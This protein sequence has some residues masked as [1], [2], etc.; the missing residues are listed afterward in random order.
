MKYILFFLM[1]AFACSV[2]GQQTEFVDFLKL[3]AEIKFSTDSSLVKGNYAV[4]FYVKTKVDTIFIDA[5]NITIITNPSISY[6]AVELKNKKLKDI[7]N[8]WDSDIEVG[9]EDDRI[10]VIYDFVENQGYKVKFDYVSNPKKA[11]YFLKRDNDWSI[12]TQGQGKY[13]SNWLPSIDDVNEKME[14]NISITYDIDY[15]VI[16]NGKLIDKQINDSTITWRYDMEKPMP[17][18]LVALAIGKYNKRVETSKSGIPL[19]LYYYP[20]DS[21]KV[22][23]TY[24]YSKRM[25]DFLETE[26]GF[27]YPWQNYKQVPVH[28]FLYA[29][30]ENTSL[31]IFSDAFVVDSTGFNDK[32][33]VNVNAH[34][35]A[36]QWFGDLVTAKSGEHHWL[37]E[38]FATYYA[39]LAEGNI[40]GG[41]YYFFEL[42]KSAQDLARQDLA[43]QGTSL[44]N[45]KSSSLTFYQRGAWVLHALREKV[46]ADIYR[47]AVKN[48]LEK[49]Q[50]S[51]AETNDFINEVAVLFEGNL[52]SFVNKW[53][54]AKEFPFDDAIM[55]LKQQ[56]VFINEYI[57]IDCE[58]K[59]S[60]CTDY[61]K[62]YASD[63]AKIKVIS[64]APQLVTN[65]TFKS[66]LK[67]R[68]AIAQY[69]VDI[70]LD[71]KPN[72][73]SLIKDD[74]YL[75]KE[76][77]LYNLWVNFPEERSK[78]LN[79]LKEVYGFSDYN[80]R[81]LW[82]VLNLN[83]LEYQS[84]KNE[85]LYNELLSYTDK[86][87]NAELRMNA[88]RYLN[89][90]KACNT[91][92]QNNL[93]DAK[94]H[95]N[96]Q[97]VKFSKE[98]LEQLK[99]NQQ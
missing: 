91:E 4:D 92:C 23:S 2:N 65:N 3:E 76:Y 70:P 34:E 75:T 20:E 98:M 11:L 35:L 6:T 69:V 81:L 77:A 48:Y 52:E 78:Y 86:K 29:G 27:E 37:Q 18:Y 7:D 61:L 38:G 60:K 89:L 24:R 16:A 44:L 96:W 63:E 12:W 25:F 85:A 99:A 19:E 50:F 83:T 62:Y 54:I 15:E 73:E 67:V 47:Q 21:L 57:I 41:D 55:L 97:L 94:T 13:T 49:Y 64:Q 46:G 5:K 95:H 14:F 53:I 43:G 30:M 56:S 33:Y 51:N 74:S 22:E 68:Q 31:T 84:D 72:Y 10:F 8:R 36:H 39:L 88:F 79:T 17:S 28:D 9:F 59:T 32:N 42:Y 66:T 40:F 87:Y 1:S 71:L 45:P 93:E 58:A 80:I 82:L 26:I 90:I